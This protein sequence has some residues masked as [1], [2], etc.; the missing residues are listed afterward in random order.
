MPTGN[1]RLWD[2]SSNVRPRLATTRKRYK[3]WRRDTHTVF[4]HISFYLCRS[5]VLN[6]PPLLHFSFI[7]L[8]PRLL[9]IILPFLSSSMFIF[10]PILLLFFFTLV[11]FFFLFIFFRPSSFS[12]PPPPPSH[13]P[14]I[15]LFNFTFFWFFLTSPTLYFS[16]SFS[17]SPHIFTFPTSSSFLLLFFLSFRL[18]RLFNTPFL[19]RSSSLISKFHFLTFVLF[20][21]CFIIRNRKIIP[22]LFKSP[23][24]PFFPFLPLSPSLSFLLS[25]FSPLS[26]TT[27]PSL[28]LSLFLS[29]FVHLSHS[30][31]FP[32]FHSFHLFLFSSL[33][34]HFTL[35]RSLSLPLFLRPS[36]SL[37]LSFPF[38]HSFRLFLFSSLSF[39]LSLTSLHPLSLPLSSSL[40]LSFFV[41]LFLRPSFSPL[42][43]LPLSVSNNFPELSKFMPTS[44]ARSSQSTFPH[45]HI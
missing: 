28:A 39:L 29:F 35:S 9:Y 4:H 11:H 45:I 19:S 27:S 14:H 32:F 1:L 10:L 42:P 20:S 31:S 12:P 16:S 25:F 5:H 34:H 17:C 36:L 40:F 18:L 2:I 30:L 43:P 15:S 3:E 26:P 23:S 33:P 24:L 37:S 13:P 6:C 21:T 7:S 38:F 41:T 44:F 22:S 8:L